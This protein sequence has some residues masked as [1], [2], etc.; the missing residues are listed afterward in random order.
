MTGEVLYDPLTAQEFNLYYSFRIPTSQVVTVTVPI[1]AAYDNLASK[2][3][4]LPAPKQNTALVQCHVETAD[5]QKGL[6]FGKSC[7]KDGVHL[8]VMPLKDIALRGPEKALR[9]F[10]SWEEF[11]QPAR[12]M[13]EVDMDEATGRVVVW[14]WDRDTRAVKIFFGDLV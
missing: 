9:M 4:E 11:E 12:Q 2:S 7:K 6:Y 14:L 10:V 1:N 13:V 3:A 5:C 8:L